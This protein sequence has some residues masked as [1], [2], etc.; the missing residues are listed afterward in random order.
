MNT[1]RLFLKAVLLLLAVI[2]QAC[3][4]AMRARMLAATPDAVSLPSQPTA[5]LPVPTSTSVSTATPQPTIT[6]TAIPTQTTTC[7]ENIFEPQVFIPD[8]L[9]LLAR[10]DSPEE[11]FGVQT[12]DLVSGAV[13][14]S[15]ESP[16]MVYL[17]AL[18]P[19]GETLAWALEDNSIQLLSYPQGE[20]L[21]SWSAHTQRI[22]SLKFSPDGQLLYTASYD[23][24][25]RV[26]DM[27]GELVDEFLPGGFEVHA[28]GIS[29]D[30]RLAVTV[31]FEGPQK[32]WD[33]E[34]GQMIANLIP[35]GAFSPS[36][37]VFSADGSMVGITLG[38]GPVS[39]WTVPGGEQIWSGGNFSL[40]LSQDG[41]YL[42][43]TDV[44]EDGSNKV[45]IANQDG[46]K[47]LRTLDDLPSFA[48][49]LVFS[50]DGSLLVESSNVVRVWD[51]DTGE[52]RYIF[53]GTCP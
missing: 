8:S 27:Q 42:A 23:N 39:L 20:L 49:K 7:I 18:S 19:D 30:G 9:L 41:R 38:S 35:N 44:N 29:P 2:L 17:V 28:I 24:W 4:P 43:Y 5:S 48:W 51:V 10:K 34:A 40:A 1:K 52:L 12:I 46:S 6:E 33:L 11:G 32:L 26:W 45:V 50:P 36:E 3:T 25:I 16:K 13:E 53:K 15:L 31:T 37:V 22:E 14:S 47:V 21:H